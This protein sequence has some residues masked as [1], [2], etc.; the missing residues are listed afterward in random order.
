MEYI[1]L[2]WMGDERGNQIPEGVNVLPLSVPI[3]THPLHAVGIA[4]AGKLRGE[5][6]VAATYF[7]DGATSEGDV[8]EALNFASAL[9]VPVV[10]VCQNN[11]WAISTPREKQMANKYV[12]QRALGYE[13]ECIQVDGN[14]LFACYKAMRD[15][16]KYA[17]E[18]NK[19]YF[20]EAMTF[21]MGDHTTA[22]DARRY[23]DQA[24]VDEWAGKCPL[25]R[26][27]IWLEAQ[28][29]WD[30]AQQDALDAEADETTKRVVQT[31]FDIVKPSTDDIFNYTFAEI[32]ED[33]KRQR[34]TMRTN[35]LAQFPE[36]E[37]LRAGT[38]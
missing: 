15:A 5:G 27:R 20:I 2:H 32:P 13:I 34:D 3:G 9:K 33:M 23:R 18:T 21:R 28:G 4:W 1:L 22:D 16:V 7:G 24:E 36:Q 19:P 38:V 11:G 12:V 25:K 26:L 8:H 30:Q 37:T 31:A 10:F 29:A 6:T 17:R 35:S 14:D